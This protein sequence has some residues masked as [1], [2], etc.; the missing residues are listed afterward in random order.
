M[1]TDTFEHYRQALA[2]LPADKFIG[3]IL[4]FTVPDPSITRSDL[5]Q[6]FF[7]LGLDERF[8]PRPISAVNAFRRA[9]GEA[10]NEYDLPQEG[11]S[12]L[13]FIEEVDYDSERV[14]RHVMRRVRDRKGKQLS[15]ETV[16]Q[17]VFYRASRAAKAR[18]LGG[19]SVKWTILDQRLTL[20]SDEHDIVRDFIN[21]T[22]QS[23]RHLC[24]YLTP[25]AIRAVFRNYI[26]FLNAISV[27]PSGGVYFVHRTRQDTVDLL[28]ELARR[29]SGGV[30]LH[31]LPLIDTEEQRDMLSEAYQDE[32]EKE[33]EKL[34]G[35]VA[36]INA[37]HKG[38]IPPGKYA[39][40]QEAW[41]DL[42]ERSKEYTTIFNARQERA[43]SALELALD[44]VVDM[45][46]RLDTG[47]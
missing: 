28:T 35:Q 16:G 13:L 20:R 21:E 5:E 31:S 23:Y 44:A 1:T 41:N 15:Y 9:T 27:R 17:A 12:A 10:E 18:G 2:G 14:E 30:A 47:K 45:A 32:V 19:E 43:G 11:Q 42:S 38:K 7:D 22:N 3:S 25:D 40:L 29:L 24:D 26:A 34:L 4:W 46:Q 37:K 8:L 33:V 36:E 6:H 39:E